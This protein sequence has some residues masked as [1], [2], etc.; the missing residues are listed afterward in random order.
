[1]VN[2]LEIPD[3][4]GLL[5]SL[6][7]AVQLCR[8][9]EEIAPKFG[10]HVA[11]TGG[12]LYK[13]GLRK[14]CDLLFYRIRQTE[15]IDLNG[16]FKSLSGLMT[17]LWDRPAHNWVM[18]CSEPKT[19]RTIDCFFPELGEREPLERFPNDDASCSG[20]LLTNDMPWA[21]LRHVYF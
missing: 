17:P 2:P 16:L 13:D 3:E 19:G 4:G 14:D 6:D 15:E 10:C 18:K 1:M 5:W 7:E 9:V 12:T 20:I 11:L 8:K 21:I